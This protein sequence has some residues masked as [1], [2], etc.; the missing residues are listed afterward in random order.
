M[1]GVFD[2]ID[3]AWFESLFG[4]YGNIIIAAVALSVVVIGFLAAI[5][6][7]L[8]ARV[9][10]DERENGYARLEKERA[11]SQQHQRAVVTKDALLERKDEALKQAAGML[12]SQQATLNAQQEE[13]STREQCLDSL[14]LAF[15]GKDHDL[16]CVHPA[17]KPDD[18]DSRISH[19]RREKPIILIANMRAGVGKTTLTA[20]LA[21]RFAE[22]GK[23]V[24]LVDADHQGTLSHMVLSADGVAEFTSQLNK[25]L[26]PGSDLDAYESAVVPFTKRL[27]RSGIV[28]A[29]SPLAAIE[30]RL[31]IEYLLQEDNEWDD[32]R[33]RLASLL[34]NDDVAETYDIALIDAPPRLTAATVNGFCAATHLLVPTVYD[35]MSAEALG[36]FLDGTRVMRAW[37]NPGI[38]LLGVVGMQ[39]T[40]HDKLNAREQVAQK[41]IK[42]ELARTWG[43]NAHVFDRHIA[44]KESIATAVGDDIAFYADREVRRWFDALGDAVQQ[45][46]TD[47]A[48]T[49]RQP[50]GADEWSEWVRTA[51][52]TAAE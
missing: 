48:K 22:A 24:L 16:W 5:L 25:L 27:K 8:H 33:Y 31:K 13:I 37:L 52:A 51:M 46:L 1:M 30:S 9:L 36:G 28:A 29:K 38:D 2:T 15:V 39:T 18:Y 42:N 6:R 34:L 4:R 41:L 26:A 7:Y 3:W 40:Q 35:T 19:H 12:K 45:R 23:R 11:V 50:R 10:Q 32:G 14:R 47:Q 17:R 49:N 20:N 44:R 43:A 21:A